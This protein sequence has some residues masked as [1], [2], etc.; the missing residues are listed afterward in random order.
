MVQDCG[1]TDF[2][3]ISVLCDSIVDVYRSA[4][5]KPLKNAAFDSR[6]SVLVH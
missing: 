6:V 1:S 4:D 5:P 2:A 3:F